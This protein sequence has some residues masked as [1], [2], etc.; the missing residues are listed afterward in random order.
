MRPVPDHR[1]DVDNRAS[2]GIVLASSERAGALFAAA[3]ARYLVLRDGLSD[4]QVFRDRAPDGLAMTLAEG[5][6][7]RWLRAIRLAGMPFR[8]CETTAR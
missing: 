4:M 3:G 6:T 7:P 2:L 5:R 1:D 8:V